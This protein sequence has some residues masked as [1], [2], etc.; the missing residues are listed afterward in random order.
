MGTKQCAIASCEKQWE[1][2]G[3]KTTA[4]TSVWVYLGNG[5]IGI[6]WHILPPSVSSDSVKMCPC[7]RDQKQ[8]AQRSEHSFGLLFLLLLRILVLLLFLLLF[9]LLLDVAFRVLL[10]S[11]VRLKREMKRVRSIALP[12][13]YLAHSPV[14]GPCFAYLTPSSTCPFWCSCSSRTVQSPRCR[15]RRLPCRPPSSPRPCWL[16]SI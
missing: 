9:V 15:D 16:P 5:R 1:E 14:L 7:V 13:S 8:N 12:Q 4:I 11:V 10:F 6:D 3:R 2:K